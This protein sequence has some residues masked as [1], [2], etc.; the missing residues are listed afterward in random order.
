MAMSSA[1]PSSGPRTL[2][3]SEVHERCMEKGYR[4]AEIEEAL[5]D[6]ESLNVLSIN[7]SKTKITLINAA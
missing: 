2:K 1:K 7:Q 6:Y 5:E 4:P 3:M